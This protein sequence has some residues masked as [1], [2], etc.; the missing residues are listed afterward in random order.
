MI[1]QMNINDNNIV[2]V[3]PSL[4]SGGAERVISVLANNWIEKGYKVNLILWNAENKF[5]AINK[6]INIIDLNFRY[7]NRIERL[8]KQLIVIYSLRQQLKILK[9]KFVLS[10]LSLNNIVTLIS[11]LF[12]N[13]KIIISE[14]NNPKELSIDLSERL[15]FVRKFLYKNFADGIICQTELAKELISKEFPKIKISSIPNPIKMPNT[16]RKHVEE[17]LLLNI[18]RLHPQK[19]QLD[20]LDIISKLETKNFKLIILGEGPLRSELEIKIKELNLEKNVYLKGA[21]DNI[22]E[23]LSKS[24]IFVFPSKYEGFPN[25]LA[26]AMLAGVPSISYDCDTGPKQLINDSVN[27]FLINLNDKQDFTN[28]IDLLLNNKELRNRFS[29]ESKKLIHELNEDIISEKYLQFCM[30]SSK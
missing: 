10:F 4:T 29:S 23:W 28:K 8:Y 27:G 2:I 25:A 17:N 12:L 16:N 20:L 3:M 22:E 21:V 13:T 6:N 5:Y 1:L 15:F 30:E 11:S 26:E 19:G 18:G 9:P 7:K 14:R 24:S